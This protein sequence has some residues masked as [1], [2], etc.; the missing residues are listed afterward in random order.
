MAMLGTMVGRIWTFWSLVSE[1]LPDVLISLPSIDLITCCIW[2][3]RTYKMDPNVLSSPLVFV[4]LVTPVDVLPWLP[5]YFVISTIVV[6]N[7]KLSQFS[8]YFWCCFVLFLCFPPVVFNITFWS[9]FA[10]LL[11]WPFTGNNSGT[12]SLIYYAYTNVQSSWWLFR[13]RKETHLRCIHLF[14]IPYDLVLSILR[15][16]Y[17]MKKT[18]MERIQLAATFEITS[19]D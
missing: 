14:I 6:P 10:T 7:C 12:S 5:V 8:Q 3:W 16:Y 11:I 9:L 19:K 13:R 1:P 2:F 17:F 18:S 4:R 15:E